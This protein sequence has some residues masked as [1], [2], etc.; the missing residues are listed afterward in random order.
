MNHICPFS[1]YNRSHKTILLVIR[2]H[3]CLVDQHPPIQQSKYIYQPF[4]FIFYFFNQP[5]IIERR[6]PTLYYAGM[7]GIELIS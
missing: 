2:V 5:F 4:I 3:S 1:L 6:K 7:S